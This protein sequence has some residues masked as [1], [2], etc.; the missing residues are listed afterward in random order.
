MGRKEGSSYWGSPV[1]P[2]PLPFL[3]SFLSKPYIYF[4][5]VC[6]IRKLPIFQTNMDDYFPFLLFLSILHMK[7][8]FSHVLMDESSDSSVQFLPLVYCLRFCFVE[9]NCFT[10]YYTLYF[11]LNCTFISINSKV[12]IF[13]MQQYYWQWIFPPSFKCHSMPSWIW[14]HWL[15]CWL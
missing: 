8:I 13:W 4:S 5:R 6:I 7:F 11:V 10:L 9:M 1:M 14:D 3:Q 15:E 12:E 2:W